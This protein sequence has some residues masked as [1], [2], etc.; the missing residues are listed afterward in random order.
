MAGGGKDRSSTSIQITCIYICHI[1]VPCLYC[2]FSQP[3][4]VIG[5]NEVLSD[6]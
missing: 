5:V 1:Y 2:E 3:N 6:R 4:V